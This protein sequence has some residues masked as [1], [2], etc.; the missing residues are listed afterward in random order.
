MIYSL[1]HMFYYKSVLCPTT[2]EASAS[3]QRIFIKSSLFAFLDTITLQYIYTL[4]NFINNLHDKTTPQRYQA[5]P[6][7]FWESSHKLI[8]LFTSDQQQYSLYIYLHTCSFSYQLLPFW[9]PTSILKLCIADLRGIQ[10]LG[11]PAKEK[12][13]SSTSGMSL[14]KLL[15]MLLWKSTL[16]HQAS[17]SQSHLTF[18]AQIQHTSYHMIRTTPVPSTG[19]IKLLPDKLCFLLI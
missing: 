7:G 13:K 6:H 12:N 4:G 1:V 2:G 11:I 14:C 3:S 18:S 17:F 16:L 5:L 9:T 8:I 15:H 10:I 19:K